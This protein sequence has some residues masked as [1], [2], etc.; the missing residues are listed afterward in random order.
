MSSLAFNVPINS[1]SFGQVSLSILRELYYKSVEPVIF[2]ISG[3]IDPSDSSLVEEPADFIDW[4]KKCERKSLFHERESP[5]FKLWHLNG[6]LE[7]FSKEQALMTFYECDSPTP[8]ELNAAKNNK[9]LVT[10]NYTHEIFKKNGINST[11]IPLG[12]DEYNFK[13]KEKKYFDDD[14]ICFNLY[15]KF[16]KRK[17][18]RKIIQAWIKKFGNDKKY[19]LQCALWNNFFSEED[20]RNNFLSCVDGKPYFN[21]QF[22]SFLPS[23]KLYNDLLNSAHIVIAMS[24]GEGWGLPE[25]QSLCLG[26]HAVVLDAHA[27]K[28]WANKGNSTLVSPSKQMDSHDGFFFKKGSQFNQGSFYDF[29]EDEFINACEESIKKFKENNTNRAGVELKD[30]FSYKR[31]T[32]KIIETLEDM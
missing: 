3:P 5:C 14:R 23:N 16:E 1:G 15:G 17:N 24:G 8:A 32:E 22:L 6:A 26:K 12:F 2:P 21:V 7:S 10:N 18:H 29:N 9:L 13:V 20:N 11:V 19:Y 25:F 31:T 30:K 28:D 4:I 27:Y